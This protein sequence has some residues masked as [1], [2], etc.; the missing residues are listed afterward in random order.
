MNRVG[1]VVLPQQ[2][3][4][5]GL[6]YLLAGL[7]MLMAAPA[8]AA[9]STASLSLS[10]AVKLAATRAPQAQAQLLRAQ[11]A[12][13]DAVR[14]GRLPDPGLTVGINNLT[15]TGPQAFDIGADDMTMRSIGVMQAIPAPAK[16]EAAKDVAKAQVQLAGAMAVQTRLAVKRAAANAWVQLWAA[17]RKRSLLDDLRKQSALAVTITKARLQGGTGSATAVLAAQAAVVKLDN[18]IVAVES[19]TAAARAALQRWIGKRADSTLAMAPGFSMLPVSAFHLTKNLDLQGPLLGW[20][21]RQQ[22]AQ[23]KLELAKAGKR[24]DWSVSLMYGERVNLPD[25]TSI[26]VGVSLPI[27]TGNRQDRDIGARAAELAAVKADREAALREQRAAV[28]ALLAKWKAAG[29]QVSTYRDKLLPLT[30]D[31]TRTALGQYQGGG[32]LQPWLQARSAEI[33]TR[34]AYADTLEAR[35][36][37]WVQLA[38]LIPD[39]KASHTNAVEEQ[40]P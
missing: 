37:A 13:E 10:A 6:G 7:L 17:Q 15:V 34:I 36:R 31:R 2:R 24:P 30:A 25:M 1:P 20:S 14:A 29:Q 19:D 3:P 9:N 16:R 28:T 26:Q 35:G 39:Y 12:Q 32:S 40:L 8:H 21:A 11:A 22:Q 23:A 4:K 33:D 38:Y 5:S 18:R 27:F